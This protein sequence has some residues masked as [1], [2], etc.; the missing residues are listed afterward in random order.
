MELL[1]SLV[2]GVLSASG[3]YLLLRGRTFSIIVGLALLS[4]AVNLFLFSMGGLHTHAAAVIGE[5]ESPADPLPQALVLTA[6]VIGFA[7]TAFMVILAIRA[8]AE[9]GNDHVDGKQGEEGETR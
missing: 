2:T 6:I 8:R 3:I 9:L 7:M 5:S 1:F 4:Y